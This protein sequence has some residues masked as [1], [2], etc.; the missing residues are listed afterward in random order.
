MTKKF[1]RKRIEFKKDS[2][3][4][5]RLRKQDRVL[6]SGP[7]EIEVTNITVSPGLDY[8][9]TLIISTPLSTEMVKLGPG[10]KHSGGTSGKKE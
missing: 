8:E 1:E 10:S 7:S 9:V 3:M 5:T 2:C 4:T 6:L